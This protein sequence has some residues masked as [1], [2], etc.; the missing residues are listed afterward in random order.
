VLLSEE[1]KR[2]RRR[3]YERRPDVVARKRAF[4]EAYYNREIKTD[5]MEA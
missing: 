4:R 3:V 1:E 2:E 5:H